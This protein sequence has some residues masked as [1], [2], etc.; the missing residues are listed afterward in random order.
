MNILEAVNVYKEIS[1]STNV[2][3]VS[4]CINCSYRLKQSE[5]HLNHVF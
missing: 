3:D 5:H 4:K 2:F 1:L